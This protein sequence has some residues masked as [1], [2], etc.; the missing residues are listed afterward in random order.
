MNTLSSSEQEYLVDLYLFQGWTQQQ[1]AWSFR[2]DKADV[3][4]ISVFYLMYGYVPADMEGTVRPSAP[5]GALSNDELDFLREIM[6]EDPTLYL[7]EYCTAL[8]VQHHLSVSVSTMFRIL[9]YLDATYKVCYRKAQQASPYLEGKFLNDVEYLWRELI[10]WG[11]EFGTDRN[12]IMHRRRGRAIRGERAIDRGLLYD[13]KHYSCLAFLSCEGI[14]GHYTVPGAIN[15]DRLV[16]YT[17]TQLIP[18]M[19]EKG[20]TT[21]IMDNCRIHHTDRFK[22]LLDV[23]GI[24]LRFLPPYSPWLNP[25]EEAFRKVKQWLHRH[26]KNYKYNGHTLYTLILMALSEVSENDC[27]SFINDC[28]YF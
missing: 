27:Q 14:I 9:K 2:I 24:N 6:E 7:D 23:A 5:P 21:L 28:K 17:E 22:H 8:L 16:Y 26:A 3:K 18:I 25:I 19:H 1:C 20:L 15:T 12:D 4:P 13:R 11:D 10:V